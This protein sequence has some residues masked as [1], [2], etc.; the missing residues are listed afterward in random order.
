MIL[1][2]YLFL[3]IYSIVIRFNFYVYD[4]FVVNEIGIC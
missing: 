1:M 2:E 4:M 3:D